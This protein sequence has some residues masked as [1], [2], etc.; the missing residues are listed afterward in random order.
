[1]AT[2]GPIRRMPSI[3]V[4]LDFVIPDSSY[5][6]EWGQLPSPD[7]VRAKAK[8]QHLTGET[9]ICSNIF[10]T[11]L[12]GPQ[13]KPPPAEAQHLTRDTLSCRNHFD[14]DLDGPQGKPPPAVFRDRNLLVKWGTGVNISEAHSLFAIGQLDDIPVPQIFGWCVDRGET[15]IYMEYI[16]GQTLEQAWYSMDEDHR[17]SVCHELREIV[18]AL[19]QI[20]QDPLDPFI[21]KYNDCKTGNEYVKSIGITRLV[22]S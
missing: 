16:Q 14:I 4:S 5:L 8:A 13:S 2:K 22:E 9:L 18:D 15:F 10:E 21:G 3:P 20:K 19:R 7:E 17:I 6:R 12:E 1:M 11:D